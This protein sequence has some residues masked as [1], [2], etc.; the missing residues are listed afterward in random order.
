MPRTYIIIIVVI[1]YYGD[2]QNG[3]DLI[4]KYYNNGLSL[5]TV[6]YHLLVKPRIYQQYIVSS[7][8]NYI[9]FLVFLPKSKHLIILK[10]ML[11]L[12]FVLQILLI[13]SIH[14]IY[15]KYN[16]QSV[17]E[18]KYFFLIQKNS[19]S[20][21]IICIQSMHLDN[22]IMRRGLIKWRRKFSSIFMKNLRIYAL[23]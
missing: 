6:E 5:Y 8:G 11:V 14:I 22:M 17:L 19:N 1:L 16:Y 4:H 9:Y 12:L 18:I 15:V 13:L 10:Q 21:V 23:R 2:F 3:I 7:N 20:V